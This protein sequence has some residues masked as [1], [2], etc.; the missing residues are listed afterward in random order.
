M[1]EKIIIF[2]IGVLFGA[3]LSTGAFYLYTIN[4]D[5]Y[6]SNNPSM[7]MKEG[8]RPEKPGEKN[9]QPPEKP[10]SGSSNH[11]KKSGTDNTSENKK[12]KKSNDNKSE[13]N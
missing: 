5:S 4:S 7:Q 9:G 3:V 11:S 1:K 10:S 12:V 6:N 2:I 8:N 13:S